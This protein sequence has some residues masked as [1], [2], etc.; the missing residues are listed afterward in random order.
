MC[1]GTQ[2]PGPRG[3]GPWAKGPGPLGQGAPYYN[4]TSGT[5]R[6]KPVRDVTGTN[7]YKEKTGANRYNPVRFITGLPLD[8][9]DSI[10]YMFENEPVQSGSKQ[11]Q[12]V[13]TNPIQH[14]AF[15]K[16]QILNKQ[17]L[18][19]NCKTEITYNINNMPS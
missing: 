19:E 6:Y 13:Q 11:K 15:L 2:A 7:R 8:Q 5:N 18:Y 9:S 12:P 1:Q 14:T 4:D 10:Q 17:L 3:P 16:R